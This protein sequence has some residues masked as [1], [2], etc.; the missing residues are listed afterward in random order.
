MTKRKALAVWLAWLACFLALEV[1]LAVG[2]VKNNGWLLVIGMSLMG[3]C[4][5]WAA[6]LRE[7]SCRA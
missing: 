7:N 5:F 2:I 6:W 1:V 4:L 3:P